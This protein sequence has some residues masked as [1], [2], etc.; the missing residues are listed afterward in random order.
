MALVV[1]WG[2]SPA[3]SD[4]TERAV[5]A[6]LELVLAGLATRVGLAADDADRGRQRC[7]RAPAPA[8]C[9]SPSRCGPGPRPR[10]ATPTAA[11]PR[12]PGEAEPSRLFRADAVV[13][14]VGGSGRPQ[15]VWA[16]LV[17]YQRELALI[18]DTLHAAIEESAGRLLVVAGP[19]RSPARSRLGA[20]LEHYIDGLAG[21]IW[22]L[23][24][25]TTAYGGAT[26]YSSL[27]AVLR[28][29]IAASDKDDLATLRGK[30]ERTTAALAITEQERAVADRAAADPAGR[31]RPRR[32]HGHLAGPSC[33][34]PGCSGSSTSAAPSRSSG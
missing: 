4:D 28:G 26:S 6:G 25:R 10:S 8:R 34:T 20:E 23:W 13:D 21:R 9:G 30:L 12:L 24:G 16:P 22:W 31:R 29:R 27:V 17:G 1:V 3:S 2:P 18:K 5:R 14:V 15:H 11:G 32:T 33:S 19:A 7:V